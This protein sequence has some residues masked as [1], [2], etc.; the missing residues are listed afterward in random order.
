MA[1][2]YR[3]HPASDAEKARAAEMKK[4]DDVK[5]KAE[6]KIADARA[7]IEEKITHAKADELVHAAHQRIIE[8]AEVVISVEIAMDVGAD[9][10][11]EDA[12]LHHLARD[13]EAEIDAVAEIELNA[14]GLRL[15]Q[16]ARHL[17]ADAHDA[18]RHA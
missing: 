1:D 17:F 8:D 9:G 10:V 14:R 5:A 7:D 13:L 16:P 11:G 4:T 3:S 2:I 6:K 18:V 12:L 15:E